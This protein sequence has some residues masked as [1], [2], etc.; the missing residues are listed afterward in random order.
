MPQ[1]A[2]RHKIVKTCTINQPESNGIKACTHAATVHMFGTARTSMRDVSLRTI[3]FKF[4]ESFPA[5]VWWLFMVEQIVKSI[6]LAFLGKVQKSWKY[7][8]VQ[9]YNMV[10]NIQE[11]WAN[12]VQSSSGRP[13][14]HS[15]TCCL[16]L[17][18]FSF[19]GASLARE[20]SKCR[21]LR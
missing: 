7:C 19:R 15:A 2:A 14:Q 11:K 4:S 6:F 17:Y 20:R 12:M 16:A 8:P 1:Q 18:I 5:W 21:G 9:C 3:T 13:F 10:D